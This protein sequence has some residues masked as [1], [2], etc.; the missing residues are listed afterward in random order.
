M[1]AFKNRAAGPP[2]CATMARA[3]RCDTPSRKESPRAEENNEQIYHHCA[4]PISIN[5]AASSPMLITML[6]LKNA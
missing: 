2:G 3:A 6:T 1:R 5:K 4:N